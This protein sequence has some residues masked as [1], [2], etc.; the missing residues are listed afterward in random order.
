M[1]YNRDI[2][3]LEKAASRWWPAHIT[4]RNAKISIIP[5]LLKSQAKFLSL[6]N[7]SKDNPYQV[8]ELIDAAK[9]PA[10]LFLKHL[11]VLADYGGEPIQ[12]LGR[13]F[14]SLFLNS[15]GKYRIK[16]HWK[17]NAYTYEFKHLP[18]KGLSNSK[19]AIDGN[20]L[21]T[22]TSLTELYQDMIVLLMFGAASDASN[23][24]GLAS[25]EIGMLLGEDELLTKYVTQRYIYVSRITGRAT[26][27][28]MGQLA[29]TDVVTYLKTKLGALYSVTSNG[30]ITLNGD[31]KDSMPFDI[32][33]AKANKKAGI[34]VS[35]QVTTNSTIE[36]KSGQAAARQ[37]LM[38]KNGYKIA[39]VLD[40]AGNFQR[41]SAI[42]EICNKSDCTVAFSQAEFAILVQWLKKV[43]G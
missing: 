19:L 20:G 17:S 26:A 24:A 33:V 16:F 34:E 30:K 15:D 35:F 38:H 42:T 32:V 23:E 9:F 13:A 10:N 28:T 43:L 7:L 12:R 31:D 40:G 6:L 1:K 29:Q 37:S 11:S 39:Y 27:N 41:K 5:Q 3:E 2:I 4:D 8:F 25:C 22:Q 18:I 21:A 36:R 14:D